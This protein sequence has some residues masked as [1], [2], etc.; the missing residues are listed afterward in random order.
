MSVF[1]SWVYIPK[2][3]HTSASKLIQ[4]GKKKKGVYLK[5]KAYLKHKHLVQW[6]TDSIFSLL[7]T[8]SIYLNI[9]KNNKENLLLVF[10][11]FSVTFL[12]GLDIWPLILFSLHCSDSRASYL[13][14]NKN[15]SEQMKYIIFLVWEGLQ[16]LVTYFSAIFVGFTDRMGHTAL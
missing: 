15:Q 14:L 1:S 10:C 5:F 11:F 7:I 3:C 9:K 6:V 12:E 16:C 4:K 8:K 13:A 2:L